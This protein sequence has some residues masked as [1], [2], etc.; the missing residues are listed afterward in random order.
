MPHPA[1]NDHPFTMDGE[2]DD[3]LDFLLEERQATLRNVLEKKRA[4][5]D[6]LE[7]TWSCETEASK[8]L[9][10]KCDSAACGWGEAHFWKE[11]ID[12]VIFY[13]IENPQQANNG[14]HTLGSQRCWYPMSASLWAMLFSR[15]PSVIRLLG[16]RH[17]ASCSPML[18]DGVGQRPKVW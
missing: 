15:T 4:M 11:S 14:E 9:A 8:L 1:H 17:C 16:T 2:D 3:Y 18:P 12:G 13:L 6:A 7:I 5:I 10:A